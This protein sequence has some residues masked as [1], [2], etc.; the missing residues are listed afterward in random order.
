[1]FAGTLLG[2]AADNQHFHIVMRAGFRLKSILVAQV[3]R[4]V[5]QLTPAARARFN[6]GRVYSLVS[7]DAGAC[8]CAAC[9]PWCVLSKPF[10]G[11]GGGGAAAGLALQLTTLPPRSQPPHNPAS[12]PTAFLAPPPTPPQLLPLRDAETLQNVCQNAFGFV[13]SPLRIAIAMVLLYR[14][15]GPA[16]L[17]AV[18]GGTYPFHPP[19]R[20]RPGSRGCKQFS[21]KARTA[22]RPAPCLPAT[23]HL[24]PGAVPLCCRP[25]SRS[26][27]PSTRCWCAPAP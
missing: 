4:K 24:Q 2:L 27:C 5:F 3:H 11:G 22:E 7:S 10:L 19:S 12:P 15:L 20:G 9:R 25:P 18:V 23:C 17:A 13:S 21:H 1:M 8:A 14:Q 26:A 16:S 6:S